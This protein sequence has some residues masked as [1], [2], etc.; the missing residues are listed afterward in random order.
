MHK[1]NCDSIDV[2]SLMGNSE[3]WDIFAVALEK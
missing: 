3:N 2:F 1:T